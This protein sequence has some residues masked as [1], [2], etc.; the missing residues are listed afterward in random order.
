MSKKKAE[1]FQFAKNQVP[2][3]IELLSSVVSSIGVRAIWQT[4]KILEKILATGIEPTKM[5]GPTI[6]QKSTKNQVCKTHVLVGF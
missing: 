3:G 1:K 2:T 6:G 5:G 4:V